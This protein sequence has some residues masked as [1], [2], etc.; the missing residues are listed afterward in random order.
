MFRYLISILKNFNIF[1][2]VHR[3]LGVHISYVKS[4]NLDKWPKGAPETFTKL[5]K[6]YLNPRILD[7]KII[8]AY[9]EK[10]LKEMD[11]SKLQDD[12]YLLNEFIRD[13]YERKRY[14]A[15]G[16]HPMEYIK[17]GKEPVVESSKEETN[18]IKNNEKEQIKN[19]E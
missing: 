6:L 12:D 7:N 10:N 9:W 4:V 19:K 11:Y 15:K 5:S 18:K 2:G 13:K 1:I 16:K 3:A 17:E 8:N 14:S